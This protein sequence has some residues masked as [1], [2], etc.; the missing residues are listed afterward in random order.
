MYLQ[1]SINAICELKCFVTEPECVKPGLDWQTQAF[2]SHQ[3]L[4]WG[5]FGKDCSHY[6]H[7]MLLHLKNKMI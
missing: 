6:S 2:F 5:N 1:H 7:R 4:L 3:L